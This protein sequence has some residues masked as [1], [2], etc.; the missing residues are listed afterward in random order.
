MTRA[1]ALPP[2]LQQS[3]HARFVAQSSNGPLTRA[4]AQRIV[5]EMP[6]ERTRRAMAALL[7]RRIVEPKLREIPTVA[8]LAALE[9]HKSHWVYFIGCGRGPIKIGVAT[10]VLARL[11]DLQT[12]CPYEL[13]LLGKIP[14]SKAAERALHNVFA[15]FRVRGEW[16]AGTPE[17]R[18]AIRSLIDQVP[19]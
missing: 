3:N 16:F 2:A 4:T 6:D 7:E 15:A 12:G 8:W 9:P 19:R 11:H 5:N 14:G 17:V 18:R 13:R 1:E 10:D